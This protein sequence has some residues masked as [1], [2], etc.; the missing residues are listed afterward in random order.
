MLRNAQPLPK[1]ALIASSRYLVIILTPLPAA[2]GA[3]VVLLALSIYAPLIDTS[4][5]VIVRDGSV[6]SSMDAV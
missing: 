5:P 4:S 1:K 3:I 2:S 6:D